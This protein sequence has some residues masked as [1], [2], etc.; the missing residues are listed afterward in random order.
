MLGDLLK[1]YSL[2]YQLLNAKPENVKRESEI[3]AQAGE[4]GRITIATNMAG[5]GTDIILGGNIKFQ[6]QREFYDL[7][8][9]AKASGKKL[10]QQDF[11]QPRHQLINL[12]TKL[13]KFM[14]F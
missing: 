4:I 9:L 7:L 14:H 6:I 8:V 10:N 2:R 5:R 13:K 1:E 11:Q 3:V 12:L